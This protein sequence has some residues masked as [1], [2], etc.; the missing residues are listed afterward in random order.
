MS[1]PARTAGCEQFPGA[2]SISC[3]FLKE[4]VRSPR[5]LI[6]RRSTSLNCQFEKLAK[7]IDALPEDLADLGDSGGLKSLMLVIRK[8]GWTS[9]AARAFPSP[10]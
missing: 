10:K 3:P 7:Q 9:V 2:V 4:T 6:M 5:I 1:L 8:A